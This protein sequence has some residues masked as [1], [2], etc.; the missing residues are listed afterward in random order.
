MPDMGYLDLPRVASKPPDV[1]RA[2]PISSRRAL[3]AVIVGGAA[4]VGFLATSPEAAS[5]AAAQAGPGLT[6]LLRAMAG[7]KAMAA[8]S[9]VATVYWRL[10][11]PIGPARFIVYALTCGTMAAGPGL[12]WDMAHL[13]L[14]AVLLHGGLFASVLLLWRD[15]NMIT[16]LEAEIARRR[17]RLRTMRPS[18]P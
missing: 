5:Q 2:M 18:Q 4:I 14:G 6:R 3:L 10:A 12:I 16:R 8:I 11:A 17:A 13:K 9:L 7:I 15:P 1:R